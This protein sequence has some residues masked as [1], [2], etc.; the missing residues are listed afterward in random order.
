MVSIISSKTTIA[1]LLSF[2]GEGEIL[3]NAEDSPLPAP[4]DGF[5]EL[6]ERKKERER[7]VRL[8]FEHWGIVTALWLANSPPVA[9]KVP[10]RSVANVAFRRWRIVVG[11]SGGGGI[12]AGAA[13]NQASDGAYEALW[14]WEW[15]CSNR[16]HEDRE[17]G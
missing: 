7:G 15:C 11:G 13:W 9:S 17:D 5:P 3:K 4:K 1:R 6:R 12:S 14:C 16:C 8:F 10:E 2:V